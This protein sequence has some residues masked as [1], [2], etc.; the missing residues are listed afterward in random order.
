MH[1]ISFTKELL[2]FWTYSNTM[3]FMVAYIALYTN[4]F[5]YKAQAYFEFF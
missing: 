3:F 2:C 1:L 4:A 5:M